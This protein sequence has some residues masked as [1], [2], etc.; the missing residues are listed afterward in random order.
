MQLIGTDDQEK[1]EEPIS[2]RV[3]RGAAMLDKVRP[4]WYM[5]INLKTLDMISRKDCV[6]GQLTG[7]YSSEE[8]YII[9]NRIE[10][11]VNLGFTRWGSRDL[12]KAWRDLTKAWRA[13]ILSRLNKARV[14]S[15]E[16]SLC[17]T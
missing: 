14:A 16:E 13:E 7:D 15:K 5:R 2:V 11:R 1:V 12:T 8:A 9:A 6:L 17:L 10:E 3:K 4:F